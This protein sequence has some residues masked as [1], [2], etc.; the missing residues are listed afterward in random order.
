MIPPPLPRTLLAEIGKVIVIWAHI[1][2]DMILHCS[3]MAAQDTNGKP[4]EYL[5]MDFKRLREKWYQLCVKRFDKKLIDKVVGPINSKLAKLSLERGYVVHGRWSVIGRGKYHLCI[6]EQKQT[7]ESL[8]SDYS[9][10]QLRGYVA[11][12][13]R[14]SKELDHFMSGRHAL[15]K[16]MKGSIAKIGDRLGPLN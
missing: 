16:N 11:A 7:L 15:F 6:F 5:R 14:A 2:Q 8:R 1:E 3:A 4:I 13:Y 9:L 12:S 10:D